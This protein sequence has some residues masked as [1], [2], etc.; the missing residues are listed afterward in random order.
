[1]QAWAGQHV[2]RNSVSVLRRKAIEWAEYAIA[3]PPYELLL[4]QRSTVARRYF[5]GL[6]SNSGSFAIFVAP[7]L[8]A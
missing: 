3:V 4:R 7:R 5:D 2:G 8:I 6:R 1:M